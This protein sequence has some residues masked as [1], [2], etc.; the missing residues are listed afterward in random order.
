M[1]SAERAAATEA[2]RARLMNPAAFAPA[3]DAPVGTIATLKLK[4]PVQLCD[5]KG[6][7][8]QVIPLVQRDG[9]VL[10]TD[11][12]EQARGLAGLL[13]WCSVPGLC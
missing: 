5:D 13:N 2:L 11:T 9:A 12:W 4:K 7:V 3:P 6:A 1:S 10:M 8:L